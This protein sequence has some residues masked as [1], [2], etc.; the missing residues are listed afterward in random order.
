MLS[1]GNVVLSRV[2]YRVLNYPHREG[3]LF[4]KHLT[5][6]SLFLAI[7]ICCAS[8]CPA[9]DVKPPPGETV[10]SRPSPESDPKSWK[11]FS[12]KDG[13]FT[14][15]FPGVPASTVN[16]IN[17]ELGKLEEHALSLKTS[18]AFYA[19]SY[20]DYSG[21]EGI[22]DVE[23]FF[24]GYRDRLLEVAH[25]QVLEERKD[26]RFANPGRFI[27]TRSDSGYVNWV[28]LHMIRQRLYI[29]FVL[30]PEKDVDT[31]TLG[32]YEETAMK[33]LN[34]FKL[35]T[36]ENGLVIGRYDRFGDPRSAKPPLLPPTGI[37]ID[38]VLR[39]G[40]DDAPYARI[41][42]G[43]LNGKALSM[44]KPEY[45]QEAKAA[46]ASGEVKV[47]IVISES[48]DVIWAQA[49]TGHELLQKSA[50]DAAYQAKFSPT[51]L[52]G[53]PERVMGVLVYKFV[54]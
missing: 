7:F 17:I 36:D 44:P 19:A 10:T 20:I 40:V 47:K 32:F 15:M 52:E 25:A 6:Y 50:R 1:Y 22:R 31:E 14:S 37:N 16:P 46:G 4:M 24:N 39:K 35:K 8:Y 26:Y 29:L 21:T 48:G 54:Q 45:S 28:R 38:P 18:L 51:T 42:G 43:V 34:S 5:R 30:M 23:A 13:S 53:K 3:N 41:N 33:F 9:Q 49:I 11:E 12:S 27:K 2:A